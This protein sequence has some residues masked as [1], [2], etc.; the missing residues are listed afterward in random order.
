MYPRMRRDS[1]PH[2]RSVAPELAPR[3]HARHWPQA[4]RRPCT[5]NVEYR[6]LQS[7][8]WIAARGVRDVLLAVLPET[9]AGS[10]PALRVACNMLDREDGREDHGRAARTRGRRGLS[11]RDHP[12]AARGSPAHSRVQLSAQSGSAASSKLDRSGRWW[13]GRKKPKHARQTNPRKSKE[14]LLD[15]AVG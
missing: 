4:P 7:N 9:R 3:F 1:L 15:P 8:A 6:I 12:C 11:G 10:S 13:Q 2:S 5:R 14:N